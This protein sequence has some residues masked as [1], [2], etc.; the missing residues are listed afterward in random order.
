MFG[1]NKGK[2]SPTNQ[3]N[4]SAN[5]IQAGTSITGEVNSEG[6]IRIDG[7]LNGSLY[8]QGKLV[9]GS[10]GNIT[11]DIRC[12]NANIEGRIEGQLE[13]KEMLILKQ[14]AVIDGDIKTLKLVVEEGAV[15]NGKIIMGSTKKNSF[16]EEKN[17]RSIQKEAV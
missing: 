8:T 13:V 9:V 3:D 4:F 14:S 17:E 11:G 2:K 12:Q 5:T 15:F 10:S 16:I 6:S 7:K 1:D